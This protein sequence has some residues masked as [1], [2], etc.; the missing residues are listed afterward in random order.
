MTD[1]VKNRELRSQQLAICE[2]YGQPCIIP[3]PDSKIGFALKTA[4][5]VP[6]NGLRHPEKADTNGW[7]IWCGEELSK[8]PDFFSPLHTAHL[9]KRDR[10]STRLNSSHL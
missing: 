2:K 9:Q 1:N 10:K 4:G 5:K 7:Y 8:A 6:I 3:P